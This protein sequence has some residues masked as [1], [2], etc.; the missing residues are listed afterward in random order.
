MN[1]RIEEISESEPELD[2]DPEEMDVE[3][4]IPPQAVYDMAY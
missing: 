1:P 2:S 3:W 4:A